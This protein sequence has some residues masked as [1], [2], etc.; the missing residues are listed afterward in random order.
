VV[1]KDYQKAVFID[2]RFGENG[3]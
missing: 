3:H 1:N 2:G